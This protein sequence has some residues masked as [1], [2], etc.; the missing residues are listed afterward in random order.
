MQIDFKNYK[1]I[2][3]Y[4]LG[5]LGDTIM[6]LPCFHKVKEV[7]P[8]GDFTLLTNRPISAKAAPV[9]SIIGR[10]FFNREITYNVGTRNP[11][12]L[13][14][15]IWK[16][17]RLGIQLV[18]NLTASRSEESAN[19]DKFFFK[20]AGIKHFIGFPESLNDFKVKIDTNTGESE[21]EA[22]RL[23]RRIKELGEINLK[24][25]R[26]WDLHL[27][28]SETNKAKMILEEYSGLQKLTISLGTKISAND[29]EEDNW[30]KLLQELRVTLNTHLLII[31]GASTDILSAER[32]SKIWGPNSLNL[33]GQLSPRESAAILK[34]SNLFVGHDSGPLHLAAA[35]GIRCIGIF[36]ARHLPKQWYPRGDDNIIIY[37]KTNCAGCNMDI[38]TIE[39]KKCILSITVKEIS[40]VINSTIAIC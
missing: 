26:Y 22:S 13:L 9:I 30:I 5:S 10:N 1:N 29:W 21:W 16:I 23:A 6:V 14:S 40:E 8:N 32:C 20:L 33:C 24:E 17:R 27:N 7:F 39:K 35:V 25:N 38:C 28:E 18:V 11:F 19:R 34:Y 36:S 12:V 4:R 31:I 3:V 2:L 37:H 15:I